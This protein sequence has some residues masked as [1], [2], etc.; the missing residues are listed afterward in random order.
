M[1][2]ARHLA[3]SDRRCLYADTG[4]HNPRWICRRSEESRWLAISMRYQ[5]THIISSPRPFPLL[6]AHKRYSPSSPMECR[7]IVICRCEHPRHVPLTRKMQ[8]CRPDHWGNFTSWGM[9]AQGI[10]SYD[11]NT[12]QVQTYR[13][14]LA[15]CA[16]WCVISL[17]IRSTLVV[18]LVLELFECDGLEWKLRLERSSV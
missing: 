10:A 13:G 17:R 11:P 4:S 15:R 14:C 1:A 6:M 7:N 12:N 3:I 18:I 9:Q 5:F 16:P 2:V 8:L